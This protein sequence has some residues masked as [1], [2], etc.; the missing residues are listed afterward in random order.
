M[1]NTRKKNTGLSKNKINNAQ[2]NMKKIKKYYLSG[3]K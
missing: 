3:S 1:F 2:K